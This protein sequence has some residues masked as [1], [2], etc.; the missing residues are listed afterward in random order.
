MGGC[1]SQARLNA[2][3]ADTRIMAG[4]KGSEGAG[5]GQERIQSRK[6]ICAA[7]RRAL[8]RRLGH[9]GLAAA[10]EDWVHRFPGE[11]EL[12]F[13]S[14]VGRSGRVNSLIG[15]GPIRPFTHSMIT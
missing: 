8:E 9:A 10:D 3:A 5:W 4:V 11:V 7:L 12:F 6:V 2:P 1:P 15:K 14:E 13:L